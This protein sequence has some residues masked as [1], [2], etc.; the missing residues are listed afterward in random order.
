M[1]TSQKI[2]TQIP[3]TIEPPKMLT[4]KSTRPASPSDLETCRN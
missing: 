1:T 3:L 2:E 4:M